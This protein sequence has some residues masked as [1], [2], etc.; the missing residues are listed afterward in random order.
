MANNVARRTNYSSYATSEV[1]Q[2]WVEAF[3][4]AIMNFTNV[5]KDLSVF[6][7]KNTLGGSLN[8]EQ[9]DVVFGECS[10]HMLCDEV[11][12][13]NTRRNNRCGATR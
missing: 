3:L 6:R 12:M 8:L 11:L 13:A 7:V 1:A 5:R 10:H 4:R 2:R 9:V